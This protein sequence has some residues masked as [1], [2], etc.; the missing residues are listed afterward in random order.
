MCSHCLFP[1]VVTS[2]YYLV[3]RLITVT[4]LLQ[5]IGPTRLKLALCN[6]LQQACC[7]QLVNNRFQSISH[8]L[9][10]LVASV[11]TFI[12]LVTR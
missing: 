9:L 10:R 8:L 12:N 3:A 4:D 2:C 6:M 11:L 1:V 7:H 5:L